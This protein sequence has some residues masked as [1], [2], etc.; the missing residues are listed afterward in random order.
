MLWND[1][2]QNIDILLFDDT[3]LLARLE[4]VLSFYS[5]SLHSSSVSRSVPFSFH[6]LRKLRSRAK[7]APNQIV[8]ALRHWPQPVT[9]CTLSMLLHFNP[10]G[11][12]EVFLVQPLTSVA[13]HCVQR[14]PP[15]EWQSAAPTTTSTTHPAAFHPH[16]S[17][18]RK[19]SCWCCQTI[20]TAAETLL[21]SQPERCR[22]QDRPQSLPTASPRQTLW[23]GSCEWGLRGWE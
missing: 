4:L 21:R 23:I 7:R 1:S 15:Y 10:L 5:Y 3:G 2:N 16:V 17:P 9:F 22:Q 14:K 12:Y 18:R 13:E 19:E 20:T 8:W 6:S 11:L